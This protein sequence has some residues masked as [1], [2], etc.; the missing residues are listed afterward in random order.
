MLPHTYLVKLTGLTHC[1][2]ILRK[3]KAVR[4]LS[5][6]KYNPIS[7]ETKLREEINQLDKWA[8]ANLLKIE[9]LYIEDLYFM[10]VIDKSI[11]L[12]QLKTFQKN[13]R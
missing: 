7:D 3:N 4:N 1:C 6:T 2:D 8:N 11:E 5:R 12:L 10:S 13:I 9:D